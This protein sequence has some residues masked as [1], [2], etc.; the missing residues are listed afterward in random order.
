M[1]EELRNAVSL[2]LTVEARF[3]ELVDP[4]TESA[5]AIST[6]VKNL[7]IAV[8]RMHERVVAMEADVAALKDHPA[9]SV[10]ALPGNVTF[11]DIPPSQPDP[12]P[13]PDTLAH[14]EGEIVTPV[15]PAP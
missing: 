4:A 5:K 6:M 13:A 11:L 10:P 12:A 1:L 2:L 7:V 3:H 14:L 15:E 8:E 9:V